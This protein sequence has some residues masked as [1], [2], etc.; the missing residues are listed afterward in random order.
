MT[1]LQGTNISA[2]ICPWDSED[3]YASHDSMY[4]KGGWREVATIAE[5]DRVT[6]PRRTAGMA[7]YVTETS[8]LYILNSDLLTWR[9][10]SDG[11]S[12]PVHNTFIHEQGVAA[13]TWTIRHD[14]GCYPSVTVVDSADNVI[15]CSVE[16]VDNSTC[17]IRMNGEF[18]GKAYLN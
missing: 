6:S 11:G 15:T 18:K 7:V 3:T 14:L 13:E 17:I 16:Y 1:K 12:V 9:V 8:T 10:F 4:G 2:K 5:R